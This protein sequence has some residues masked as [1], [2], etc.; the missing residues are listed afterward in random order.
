MLEFFKQKDKQKHILVSFI[1]VFVVGILTNSLVIGII[2]GISIGLLKE[3]YDALTMTKFFN[4]LCK[5]CKKGTPDEMDIVADSV[6]VA[7]SL[8]VLLLL[9]VPL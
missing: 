3:A 9:G 5:N 6:G 1:I 7:A 8:V 2:V 4:K